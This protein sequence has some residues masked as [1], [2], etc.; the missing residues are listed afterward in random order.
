[1]SHLHVCSVWSGEDARSLCDRRLSEAL[2][3]CLALPGRCTFSPSTAFPDCVSWSALSYLHFHDNAVVTYGDNG[4]KLAF[5]WWA[6]NGTTGRP[7]G[8]RNTLVVHTLKSRSAFSI[9]ENRPPIKWTGDAVL[10]LTPLSRTIQSSWSILTTVFYPLKAKHRRLIF[11]NPERNL[12]KLVTVPH[13][14]YIFLSAFIPLHV[15]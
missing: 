3:W 4:W 12:V 5:D 13:F 11:S 1:M 8:G 2:R 14:F 10:R 7:A 9:S 15:K 6:I